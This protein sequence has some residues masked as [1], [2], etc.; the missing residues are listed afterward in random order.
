MTPAQ[1]HGGLLL[2]VDGALRFVSAA[3]ALRVAPP[4]RLTPVPG[5]PPEFAGIAMHEGSIVPVVAVGREIGRMIVCQHGGELIAVVGAEI[6]SAGSFHVATDGT[7][8]IEHE[9]N[10]VEPFDVAAIC[11]YVH[12]GARRGGWGH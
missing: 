6:V 11:G 10:A 4:P 3:V 9:G 7:G 2:R 8:R 12:S 1:K 5:A